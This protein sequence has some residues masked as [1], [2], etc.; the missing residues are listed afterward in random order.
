MSY[1]GITILNQSLIDKEHQINVYTSPQ[2]TVFCILCLEV[3]IIIVGRKSILAEDGA[4]G[5][6]I[7]V[8]HTHTVHSPKSHLLFHLP[9]GGKK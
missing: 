9:A 2:L 4:G 8:V 1:G 6:L 3:I 5:L 7:N